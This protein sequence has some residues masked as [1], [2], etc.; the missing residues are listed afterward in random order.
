MRGKLIA[1]IYQ[2]ALQEG[3]LAYWWTRASWKTE[4]LSHPSIPSLEQA[5]ASYFVFLL[6]LSSSIRLSFALVL[7]SSLV[8]GGE[9]SAGVLS[10]D[11]LIPSQPQEPEVW[12]Y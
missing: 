8:L 6:S 9:A 5:R 7:K 2:V 12:D 10:S 4:D 1:S 11:L 3:I